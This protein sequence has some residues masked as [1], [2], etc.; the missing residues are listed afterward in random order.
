MGCFNCILF[1]LPPPNIHPP[2]SLLF[3][4]Q[5]FSLLFESMLLC[6]IFYG[7]NFTWDGDSYTFYFVCYPPQYVCVCGGM[8]VCTYVF[9][10]AYVC[11]WGSEVNIRCLPLLFFT[12]LYSHTQLDW[13]ASESRVA[14]V[15][16]SPLPML[17]MPCPAFMWVSGSWTQVLMLVQQDLFPRS[18]APAPLV[19]F[20]FL[21]DRSMLFKHRIKVCIVILVSLE[22]W[23]AHFLH[24]YSYLRDLE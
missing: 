11:V 6:F 1:G 10:C 12:L 18:H 2:L 21:T 9:A 13:L 16:A 3:S 5:R 14:P 17:C 4:E 7:I 15:P 24:Q 22:T 20:C 19:L 8:C 23:E